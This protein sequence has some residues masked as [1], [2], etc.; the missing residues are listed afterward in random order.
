MT[1]LNASNLA[2]VTEALRQLTAATKSTG[3]RF[4]SGSLLITPPTGDLLTVRWTDDGDGEYVL[5][6]G[7]N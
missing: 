7:S 5:D 2:H 1:T 6:L 3:C 4:D